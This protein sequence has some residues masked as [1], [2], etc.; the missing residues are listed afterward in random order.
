M[1]NNQHL[2]YLLFKDIDDLLVLLPF[3]WVDTV[4]QIAIKFTEN[5][6]VIVTEYSE[7]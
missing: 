6:Y 1:A 7:Q 4:P 2:E 3:L 5:C